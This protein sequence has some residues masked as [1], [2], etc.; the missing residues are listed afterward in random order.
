MAAQTS[1]IVAGAR[2]S[3]AL[4]WAALLVI[5]MPRR[6]RTWIDRCRKPVGARRVPS[7][8]P[9]TGT[10][11]TRASIMPGQTGSGPIRP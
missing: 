4:E 5:F 1:K 6:M 7:T 9:A 8:A 10:L 3:I 11:R 2:R